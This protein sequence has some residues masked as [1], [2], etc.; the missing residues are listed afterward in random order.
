MS[1]IYLESDGFVDLLLFLK[2]LFLFLGTYKNR[3]NNLYDKR[4]R[5]GKRKEK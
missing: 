1:A 3:T 2:T 5:N 4:A